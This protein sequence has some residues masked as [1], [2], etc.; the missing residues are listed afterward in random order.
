MLFNSYEFIFVFLPVTVATF[1]WLQRSKAHRLGLFWLLLAS[2]VFYVPAGLTSLAIITPSILIDYWIAR[3]LVSTSSVSER[4]RLALFVLGVALNVF[5]LCYF[6]Y[7]NFF[8]ETAGMLLAKPVDAAPALLPLGISFL[9]FQKIAFLED[10]R[11]GEVRTVKWDEFLLFAFF[12][13]RVIAGPI[14]HY[15]EV[16][17]QFSA[18]APRCPCVDLLIGMYLFSI[19][20]FKKTVIANSL[21]QLVLVTLGPAGHPELSTL[22]HTLVPAWMGLLAY[23]L[24]LY[25]DFSGYSDMA[26]G[27]ARLL[28]IRL[29]MNFNSPFKAA[30]IVD[31]WNRWHIT[32]TRIL[33]AYVYTPIAIHLTRRRLEQG[34]P[35]LQGKRSGWPAI[36]T[37]VV[38]PT[39]TTM[40]LSG[41]WHGA[42]WQFLAW[43]VLHGVYLSINQVWRLIRPRF[44]RDQA[45]YETFMRPVGQ[46]LTL[47][48]VAL[49]LVFFRSASLAAAL[50]VL[51]DLG[52]IH[53]TSIADLQAIERLNMNVHF[54]LL[55]LGI[56][57]S[58]PWCLIALLIAVMLMPNSLELLRRFQ[59]ALDF[60]QE[61]P[62]TQPRYPGMDLSPLTTVFA[63]LL[64]AL[65]VMAIGP[66]GGFIYGQF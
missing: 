41:L 44:W 19:G 25:F 9:V 16:V 32:L 34:L 35:V 50:P 27:A 63:A 5:F 13:P 49:A 17:P 46:A 14:V 65:G 15:N 55:H 20:L 59:P 37:L 53:G 21:A 23:T 61:T 31:F 7:R 11:S 58:A 51:K 54:P 18:P 60:P 64:C 28:G 22:P 52:E 40:T 36:G 3:A 10:V 6:K 39:L 43:G 57:L 24:Q 33:T 8:L 56:S 66:D 1:R 30:S 12:F 47:L 26:L 48:C 2:I 62:S 38:F 45:R 4:T 29:P 42:G